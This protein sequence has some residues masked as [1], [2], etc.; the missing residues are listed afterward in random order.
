M[1][2]GHICMHAFPPSR[3]VNRRCI[4]I[5]IGI[6]YWRLEVVRSLARSSDVR[7]GPVVG[8]RACR[9]AWY[10]VRYTQFDTAYSST[11]PRCSHGIGWAVDAGPPPALIV[12]G[13]AHP[14][15]KPIPYRTVV[16]CS[17][18][19]TPRLSSLLALYYVSVR[20][21]LKKNFTKCDYVVL[22]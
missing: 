13:D 7:G 3:R 18:L 15:H 4:R 21:G 1:E 19:C 6:A 20:M 14:A 12:S 11:R 22:A 16:T 8:R 10:S 9:P 17:V 2:D 5:C